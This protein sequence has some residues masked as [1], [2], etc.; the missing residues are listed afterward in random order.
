MEASKCIAAC[1]GLMVLAGCTTKG[2]RPTQT[3]EVKIPVRAACTVATPAQPSWVVPAV[4][5]GADVF[6]QMRALLADR[7]M[8][9]AYQKELESALGACKR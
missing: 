3:V 7:E 4:P 9:F 1:V 8:A 5:K 6:E 2:E